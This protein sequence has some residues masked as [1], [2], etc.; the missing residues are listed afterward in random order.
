M[1]NK[2]ILGLGICALSLGMVAGVVGTRLAA[3]EAKADA[4]IT[5]WG[6]VGSMN[7][8]DETGDYTFEHDNVNHVYTLEVA[9]TAGDIFKI[10]A[11]GNWKDCEL[12][13]QVADHS[14]GKIAKDVGDDKNDQIN[15]GYTGTY[16]FTIKDTMTPT[17]AADYQQV[18]EY[19]TVEYAA[20]LAVYTAKLNDVNVPLESIAPSHAD[21]AA[22][23]HGTITG[24]KGQEFKVFA[25][26]AL[27]TADINHDRGS[28]VAY[29][30]NGVFALRDGVENAD[31]YV[32][33]WKSGYV[34]VWAD[35][36]AD[37]SGYYIVSSASGW[38]ANANA[39]LSDKDGESAS[40]NLAFFLNVNLAKD[41]EFTINNFDDG[42]RVNQYD[43]GWSDVVEA[44]SDQYANFELVGEE[45][46]IKVKTAGVYSIYLTSEGKICL[47]S[48]DLAPEVIKAAEDLHTY[49]AEKGAES[50]AGKTEQQMHDACVTKYTKAW[51]DYTALGEAGQKYFKDTYA[52][53]W[54]VLSYWKNRVGG[55]T[56]SYSVSGLATSNPT[57]IITISVIAGAAVAGAGIYLISKKRKHN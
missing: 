31:V 35:G 22:Q 23:Y 2:K 27:V 6:L 55:G 44:W 48:A 29:D 40:T 24:T 11:N 26:A 38:G 12:S 13:W 25:D 9:L 42:K 21:M 36:F 30:K 54:T 46:H 14:D 45:N 57:L 16:T 5:S 8:W 41:L 39:I 20:P 34:T 37:Y 56:S 10:R 7:G 4:T 33:V 1:K 17:I 18:G 19:L 15:E 51:A 50:Y 53:D 28:S 43:Y 32:K 3:V 52:T 47:N 49:I